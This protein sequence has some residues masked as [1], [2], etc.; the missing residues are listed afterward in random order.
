M[1]KLSLQNL[2]TNN[3]VTYSTFEEDKKS[4]KMSARITLSEALRIVSFGKGTILNFVGPVLIQAFE[5]MEVILICIAALKYTCESESDVGFN[6]TVLLQA[7]SFLGWVVGSILSSKPSSTIGKKPVMIMGTL[8]VVVFSVASA[9]SPSYWFFFSLRLAVG[10]FYGI[11]VGPTTPYI[12]DFTPLEHQ[13]KMESVSSSAFGIGSLFALM[14]AYIT[15]ETL[16]RNLGTYIVLCACSMLPVVLTLI[17]LTDESPVYLMQQNK[18]EEA[19]KIM[20]YLFKAN[21]LVWKYRLVED[22]KKTQSCAR[23]KCCALSYAVA[24]CH[25][26]PIIAFVFFFTTCSS[27]W[28]LL[29]SCK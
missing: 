12:K 22:P 23:Q 2:N 17:F 1:K 28:K 15:F 19:E 4:Q 6:R 7:S 21:G 27:M 10:L 16:N 5:G 25:L 18:R 3:D 8:G 14:V 13:A 26:W 11:G 9:F 29:F 20:E 24:N